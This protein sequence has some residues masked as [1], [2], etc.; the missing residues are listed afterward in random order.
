[1]RKAAWPI[2]P[3]SATPC[4]NSALPG[5]KAISFP[6]TTRKRGD[7]EADVEERF[8]L[9]MASL[10]CLAKRRANLI[11]GNALRRRE[12]GTLF[13]DTRKP[14]RLWFQ[15]MWYVTNQKQG[16]NALG[17]QRLLGLGSYRTAWTW[18]HKLRRA[19]VRPGRDRL[20]GT[21]EVDETFIGGPKPGP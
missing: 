14:L 6:Q 2:E 5:P 20:P 8:L 3:V 9:L 16:V 21:V 18:L 19:M 10:K 15:A 4:S 7:K 12:A 1:M 13:Q 11:H 17:L